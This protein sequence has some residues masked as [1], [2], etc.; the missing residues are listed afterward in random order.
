VLDITPARLFDQ[1]PKLPFRAEQT[2]CPVVHAP[3]KVFKTCQR[4]IKAIGI[5]IFRAHHTLL[6]CPQHPELG[7]YSSQE[8]ATLV[9]P[10]SNVGYNV[11]VEIG[12]L[13][14]QEQ[15]QVIEIQE[16]LMRQHAIGVS[17]SE[18]ELLIDKFI[19]YVAAV[20]QENAPLIQAQIQ[21][22]GGYILHLDA[23]CEGDSP[24]LVSSVDSVSGFV[25]FSAKILSENKED[26]AVMLK[27]IRINFGH[28]LAVI[29][30]MSL[31]I[32]AAVLEVFGN[33]AHYICHFHFLAMLGKLLFEKEHINLRNALSKVGIAGKLKA[34]KRRFVNEMNPCAN[35]EFERYL[36]QPSELGQTRD[37]TEFL[38][39]ALILWI[40]DH[41]SDGHGYGFPFD[42]RYLYFYQRLQQAYQLLDEVKAY[43]STRSDTD[44]VLWNLYHLIEKV[45]NDT[46]LKKTVAHYQ[47]KLAV[48]TELREALG[49]APASN[50]Q[51]LRQNEAPCGGQEW[52]RIRRNV[53]AFM[54]RLEQYIQTASDPT[55][56]NSFIQM[57]ERILEYWEKLFADPLVLTVNGEKRVFYLHRTN[58]IMEQQFRQLAYSYRRIHGNHSIRRNLEHIPEQI[59]LVQNL[60]NSN[61]IKLIFENASQIAKRFS[62]IDVQKIKIMAQTLNSADM[63]KIPPR[64][65]RFLRQPQFKELLK[66]AF[67]VVAT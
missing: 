7:F 50:R 11:L 56:K 34:M 57:Q 30:D 55:V 28:P 36:T 40:L 23:T 18:I 10:N 14:F 13:R 33:I 58:N 24:K 45:V 17:T 37:A 22:Q 29:S 41:P 5:G 8:L 16:T 64:A 32:A 46:G 61:Y 12:R 38:I 49:V 62:M 43:Y 60:K 48:F 3:L 39:Y 1:I 44:Q 47:T 35:H 52:A 65:K 25:L 4:T 2:H 26:L 59:P 67:S 6:Y 20:H 51:G 42:Q 27:I 54:P 9:P 63:K 66:L 31:A 53:T 19:F 21:A 15:R